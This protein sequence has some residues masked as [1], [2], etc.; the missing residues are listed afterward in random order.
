MKYITRGFLLL[1]IFWIFACST[2]NQTDNPK[3]DEIK[4][5]LGKNVTFIGKTVNMKLGA[6]L[7]LENGQRIWMDEMHSWP[8][9]FYTEKETKSAKVTGVLIER[10]DLPVFV[11]NENDSIMQ[12]GIPAP[13]DTDLK[14]ASH[15]YLFTKYK[16]NEIK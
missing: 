4:Q 15:R 3:N 14:E 7:I 12:Q 6:A 13:K 5:L 1:Q 2:T 8:D 16:W 10:H 9:G 11:P